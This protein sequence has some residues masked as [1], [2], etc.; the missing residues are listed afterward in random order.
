MPEDAGFAT[1]RSSTESSRH[2]A[3]LG[4]GGGGRSGFFG[5]GVA[6]AVWFVWIFL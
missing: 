2:D 1:H 4:F 6:G 5:D 3:F